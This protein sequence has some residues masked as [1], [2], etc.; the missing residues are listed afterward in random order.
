MVDEQLL[1][2]NW[3]LNKTSMGT[4][5]QLKHHQR[6]QKQAKPLSLS[7]AYYI[8]VFALVLFLLFIS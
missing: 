3:I 2:S 6:T 8:S 1:M 7:Q 5:K 4:D